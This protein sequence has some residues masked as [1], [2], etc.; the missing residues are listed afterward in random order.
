LIEDETLRP[1]ALAVIQRL[2][3]AGLAVEYSFTP[4]KSDKQFKR[5]LELKA[6]FT[7]KAERDADGKVA[8]RLKNLTSRAEQMLTPEAAVEEIRNA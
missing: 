7:A 1:Q 2:R 5:A 6:R 8:V 4:A 3:D